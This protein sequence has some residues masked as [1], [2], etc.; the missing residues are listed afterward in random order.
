MT[1]TK[2]IKLAQCRS[3]LK[4]TFRLFRKL[5]AGWLESLA[6]AAGCVILLA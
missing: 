4:E 2:I 1:L 6:H 3:E 5:G